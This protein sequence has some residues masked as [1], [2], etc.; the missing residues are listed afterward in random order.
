MSDFENSFQKDSGLRKDPEDQVTAYPPAYAE[1][2]S[3]PSVEEQSVYSLSP[4]AQGCHLG[5]ISLSTYILR[6]IPDA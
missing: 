3:P 4:T 6:M 2:G 1:M 5:I